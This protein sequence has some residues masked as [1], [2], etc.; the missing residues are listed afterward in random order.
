[1]LSTERTRARTQRASIAACIAVAMV[2]ALGA[3]A[4]ATSTTARGPST[5]T[6]PYVLPVADGVHITSLLTVN[7]AG[8]ASNG[9][10]MVG[11]P[12]G[13]GIMR[14]GAN[15][16]L[17]MNHEL[18]DAQGIVRRH[19]LTGA[20]VSRWVIDPTTLRIQEGS[21]FINPGVRYWDYPTASYVTTGARFANGTFQDLTF[22]RFCSGT[23][24]DPGDFYNPLTRKGWKGQ[25]YFAN[26]EDGDVGRT[27][28]VTKDGDATALPRLGLASW[29]NTKPARNRT[30]T[31]L[32]IGNEDGP[33][34]GSQVWVH[35]GTK[36]R[37]GPPIAKAGLANGSEYVIDAVN[38]AVSTDAQWRATYGKG[39]PAPVD[40]ALVDWNQAGAALNTQAKA[41]GL[42]LNRIED[43]HW[44]PNHPSDYYFFTTEGGVTGGTGLNS[45]D[46]GG[47]WRLRFANIENPSAGATLTLLLD[48]SE[49]ISATEPKLNKPD[50]MTID[51]H[52]NLLIQEDPGNVNHIARIV[53]YRIT[54]GSLAVIARF[55]PALFSAGATADP[56]KL[57]ID[58]ESSG[59]V[60]TAAFLGASTF[61]FDAQ[62]HTAKGLPAGTG[63][64]TVQEYVE[65]GQ[66]L[67]LKVDDW[68]AVYAD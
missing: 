12:D 19:G 38:E 63:P 27:F 7:D 66:L 55:D 15:L 21:D 41:V 39:V 28:G 14:Q 32:V 44:D 67:S 33:T 30:N 47:L 58:E 18:R 29:E 64:G 11:I 43:G 40:L 17:Y 37:S 68:A 8:A 59:I 1:V 26:E 9:Y 34:D 52:G 56:T 35:V 24:S 22:G 13:L 46:T 53:A 16:V 49:V 45:F 54:D 10:E 23:L 61:V 65:R 57:T 51:T 62:A 36:Q 48:G 31:T 2:A 25:I 6:D 42:S 60:D 20:F 4:A 50:N 5:T 3:P